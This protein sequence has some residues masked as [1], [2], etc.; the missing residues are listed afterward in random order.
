M[1]PR[2]AHAFTIV[3]DHDAVWLVAGEDLRFALRGEGA[4]EWL[5]ALLGACDGRLTIDEL[6]ERA[7]AARRPEARELID[8]LVGE[9][10]LVDG[11]AAAAH[12]VLPSAWSVDGTGRLADALRTREHARTGGIAVH[13]Q[14]TLELAGALAANEWHIAE[15]TPWLWA[16]I[17]PGGRALIGPLLLPD[18]GPCLECLVDHFRL[19]SPVP[20]LYDLIAAH[21][22]PFEPSAFEPAALGMVAELVAWK[23][24]LV[25]REPAPSALYALHA[26]EV[27]TLE[28]SS[29]RVLINP[30]CPAC[31]RRGT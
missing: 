22:G 27:A 24:E 13:A 31:A 23:L 7:P 29:H 30:E 18:A 5:P 1:R 6:V 19:R 12:Q 17:G 9:R 14:D 25:A 4:A 28:V 20:E 15:R 3:P 16:S 8:G 2:L 26:V 10:V 21:R 11:G